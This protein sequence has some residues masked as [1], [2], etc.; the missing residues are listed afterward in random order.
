MVPAIHWLLSKYFLN[1][2]INYP[3]VRLS[4]LFV[5]F[6]FPQLYHEAR[7]IL[8]PWSGIEPL[9]LVVNAWIL[10]HCTTREVPLSDLKKLTYLA[11][12][13]LSCRIHFKYS[14]LCFLPSSEYIPT[15]LLH[16]MGYLS[17]RVTED[18]DLLK[19]VVLLV[20]CTECVL[21]P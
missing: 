5:I 18:T 21:Y 6:F 19:A 9:L 15:Y 8:V 4:E 20:N 7:R 16:E 3:L 11:V 17:P 14:G 2:R 13:I 12:L 1:E 10:N